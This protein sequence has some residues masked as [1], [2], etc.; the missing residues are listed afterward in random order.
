MRVL[1]AV[2]NALARVRVMSGT[3]NFIVNEKPIEDYF[4][5]LGDVEQIVAPLDVAG[6]TAWTAGCHRAGQG[7]RRNRSA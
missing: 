7:R 5:R 6:E 1:A 3:G 2:K 4:T